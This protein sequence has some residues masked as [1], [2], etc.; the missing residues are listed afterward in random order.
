MSAHTL[1]NPLGKA[2][3]WIHGLF[4]L[5]PP[6]GARHHPDVHTAQELL[7]CTDFRGS[8]IPDE[9]VSA[10]HAGSPPPRASPPPPHSG[11]GRPPLLPS[12]ATCTAVL[13]E[14]LRLLLA[15]FPPSSPPHLLCHALAY[16][17]WAKYQ[18]PTVCCCE[19]KRGRKAAAVP[20]HWLGEVLVV[21]AIPR[22]HHIVDFRFGDK[23]ERQGESH[24]DTPD[25]FV[26]TLD[27]LHRLLDKRAAGA[28]RAFP[29]S[30]PPPWR[31][32][33]TFR[34]LYQCCVECD[35]TEATHCLQAMPALLCP[36]DDLGLGHLPPCSE[37]FLHPLDRP[38]VSGPPAPRPAG[39]P[40]PST[41]RTRGSSPSRRRR[42]DRT[43]S[44]T[45][46]PP[47]ACRC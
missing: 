37:A 47:V 6:G 3:R 4:P 27:D 33:A 29:G 18:W 24:A 39:T 1:F 8:V 38:V 43:P 36:T 25:V 41:P 35:P 10:P 23:F 34:R 22:T 16:V 21:S 26:G 5:R 44:A 28:D 11:P 19:P 14:E 20:R 17:V 12:A 46:T 15:A 13:Q 45:A 32:E 2:T 42:C 40:F 30:S 9:V 7:C 31:A